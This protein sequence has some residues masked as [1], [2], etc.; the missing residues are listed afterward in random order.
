MCQTLGVNGPARVLFIADAGGEIGFG[1]LMRC[2]ELAL[3]V[4]ERTGREALFL[5][6]DEEAAQR[7]EASGL[8]VEW[9]AF[10]REARPAAI[11]FTPA[12]VRELAGSSAFVVLDLFG[13][14]SLEPGWR[15]RLARP[16]LVL[17]RA[18]PWCEEA[19]LIVIPGV[20]YP[21]DWTL[22]CQL[23]GSKARVHGG[24]EFVILRREIRQLG[25]PDRER[26]IDVLA[27]LYGEAERRALADFGAAHGLTV[28]ILEEPDPD[29]PSLLASSRLFL[30]GFGI[31]FYE[32]LALG[33][34]P[35]AWPLSDQHELDARRFFSA[36]E[37]GP[38]LIRGPEEL[39]LLLELL[40]GEG[41]APATLV[42][43][44]GNIVQL[45][46]KSLPPVPDSASGAL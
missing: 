28:R 26:E 24:R 13:K 11:G 34:R 15:A 45:I 21:G 10:E 31:T 4:T 46:E 7:L 29:F 41:L 36:L 16:S 14:R 43:G 5:V 40:A 1:H 38:H 9:G 3:Q 20:T 33:T 25:A 35:V 37:L 8:S 2:R 17:D 44:T 18:A 23:R 22:P 42:D 6:D 19:E 32:A 27:Y 12:S 30:S 39:G